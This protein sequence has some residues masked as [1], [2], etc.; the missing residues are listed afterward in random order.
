MS[1]GVAPISFSGLGTGIDTASI[2]YAL[3]LERQPST[4]STTITV[5]HDTGEIEG[6]VQAFVDACNALNS[7]INAATSYDVES[8]SSGT[9]QGDQTI[10]AIR[11]Q[12]RAIAGSAVVGFAGNKY[13]PLAQIGITTS[14][15]G[16]LSLDSTTFAAALKDDPD[17]VRNVFGYTSGDSTID[18]TDGIARQPR[19]LANT[20]STETLAQRLTG[21]GD[22]LKRM[23]NR[24]DTLEE[25]MVLEEER[26]R[27]QFQA[28][29]LAVLQFQ[30]QG[31]DLATRFGILIPDEGR[32]PST[33]GDVTLL[34]E[35]KQYTA[36]SAGTASPGQWS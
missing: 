25:L 22:A 32:R 16:T 23:D 18:S 26:V 7:N 24:I 14:Q 15:D 13:D 34:R 27:Q 36:Q 4:G 9:L 31:A 8:G 3:A 5:A 29:E 28:M 12:L 6:A 17:S 10:T 30:S 33:E 1:T 20:L 35:L 11:S 21:I 19:D 2:I